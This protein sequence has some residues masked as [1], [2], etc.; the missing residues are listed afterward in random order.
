MVVIVLGLAAAAA[1]LNWPSDGGGGGPLGG[2]P[3]PELY[4]DSRLRLVARLVA[5][6]EARAR[7]DARQWLA[8]HPGR[9]D[10]AFEAFALRQVG[11]PPDAAEQ[12]R[13]LATLHAL[14]ARRTP[15]GM[16]AAQWLEAHGRK[17]IWKLYLKQ[18]RQLADKRTG[19]EAKALFR[20]TYDLADALAGDAK[21][22]F[23]RPSPYI[24]DPSLN[25]LN[26]GKFTKKVSYPARHAVTSFALAAILTSREPHRGPE[27]RWMAKEIAYSRLYAGGHYPSDVAAG[28]YLGTLVGEYELNVPPSATSP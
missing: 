19:K 15:A 27:Y 9:D 21:T 4:A 25:A 24:T 7:R 5:P 18:Y 10:R 28:A 11:P 13:E 16:A 2:E 22:R 14:G 20:A 12:R 3:Q 26:Q 17:D 23:G 8:R 1:V 6:A